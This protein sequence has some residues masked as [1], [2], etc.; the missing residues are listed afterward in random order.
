MQE[1]TGISAGPV[2]VTVTDANNCSES[3]T[4]TLNEPNILNPNISENIYSTSSNGITN[5]ISCYGLNDGWIVSNTIGGVDNMDYQYLWINDNTGLVVSTEYIA[6]N[7]QANTSYTVTVT[8]ANGCVSQSTTTILDEPDEFVANVSTLDYA[9]ATHAPFEV[10]FIDS[11]VSIDPFDFNW[12]WEDGNTYYAS[13]TSLMSHLFT[14][15]NIGENNVYVIV[16]NLAT[17]CL[18]LIHISEPTRLLSIY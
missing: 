1:E 4:I 3:Q 14:T 6:D 9:G 12:T 5:E 13:G 8:D 15:D 16:T 7:L 10:N 11:T 18:S 17:G 2:T